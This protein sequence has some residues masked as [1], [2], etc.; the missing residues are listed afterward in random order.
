M[1]LNQI[2]PPALGPES[3]EW[4]YRGKRIPSPKAGYDSKFA[5]PVLAWGSC[6]SA[7]MARGQK[8]GLRVLMGGKEVGLNGRL[9]KLEGLGW[10]LTELKPRRDAMQIWSALGGQEGE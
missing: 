10:S 1:R 6:P 4:R 7:A 9:W 2:E 3:W 8:I 5:E